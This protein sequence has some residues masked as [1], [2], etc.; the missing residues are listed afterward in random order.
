MFDNLPETN[1]QKNKKKPR[2]IAAILGVQVL[3]VSAIILVQMALPEKLGEFQLLTTLYMAPPPP[4][5]PPLSSAPAAHAQ[6]HAAQHEAVAETAATVP[7]EA[8]PVEKPQIIAPTAIPKDIAK[9]V[10][11]PGPAA[12]GIR[13]GV[14]GGIAGGVPGGLLG[15]VLGGAANAPAVPPPPEPVRV[16]GNVKQP[17]I[18]HIEQPKYPP[19]AKKAGVEGV[20][21]LEATLNA[22][23]T[24]DKVK[25]IS[26]PPMLV[27]SATE[28]LTHW[29][30]EPTY[31][32]GQA[33]PVI[34]TAKITFSLS[35]GT[36]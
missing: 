1:P 17:K 4:P 31:L 6:H 35:K 25:V 16:G 7:E 10:E 8:P 34:L 36:Q 15:G 23:G 14:A 22:D 30:Y 2:A 29:K 33:V 28:A 3:L 12:G 13:N 32:N 18:V 19:E 5:P 9:I 11:A 27:E 26:G 21:I 20:V 24:V